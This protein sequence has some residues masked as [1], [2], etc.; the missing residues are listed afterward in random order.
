ML[1][2]FF[3]T[4]VDSDSFFYWRTRF[5]KKTRK[6]GRS[7]D[8]PPTG[9]AH[10]DSRFP[11]AISLANYEELSAVSQNARNSAIETKRTVR[12]GPF[13]GDKAWPICG[14]AGVRMTVA[15]RQRKAGLAPFYICQGPREV[16]RTRYGHCNDLL[17]RQPRN[18]WR[19]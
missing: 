13:A 3:A 12:E 1:H 9:M 17:G 14:V 2:V 8:L 10:V 5:Q 7:R 19:G 15:Y 11:R 6:V 16:D 18:N 4:L